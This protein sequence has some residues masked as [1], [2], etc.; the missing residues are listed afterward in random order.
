MNAKTAAAVTGNLLEPVE[1]RETPAIR[2]ETRE[3]IWERDTK[4]KAVMQEKEIPG[5]APIVG[6]LYVGKW[7]RQG[8]TLI[9]VTF[10]RKN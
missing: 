1:M 4:N 7:F 2:T 6:A 5:K 8:S 3:F 10:E 9:Q